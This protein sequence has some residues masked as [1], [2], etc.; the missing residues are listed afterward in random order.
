M[1]ANEQ[2]ERLA[3][4]RDKRKENKSSGAKSESSGRF[5]KAVK[6]KNTNKKTALENSRG[7]LTMECALCKLI[8]GNYKSHRT[9]DCNRK[10]S[11]VVAM[12]VRA[13]ALR[14]AD[15]YKFKDSNDRSDK[16]RFCY[17]KEHFR[18]S[19]QSRRRKCSHGDRKKNRRKKGKFNWTKLYQDSFQEIK[20]VVAREVSLSFP[21]FSYLSICIPMQ[22]IDN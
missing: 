10:S 9:E 20:R 7:S 16:G 3:Q 6:M 12:D 4:E 1:E 18:A 14:D 15:R 11:F 8:K 2:S 21:D 17:A 13:K 22:V 19:C 5:D